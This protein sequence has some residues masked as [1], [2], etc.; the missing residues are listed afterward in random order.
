SAE[1]TNRNDAPVP[2]ADVGF[3]D[4]IGCRGDTAADEKIEGLCHSQEL[5]RAFRLGNRS[6]QDYLMGM[7]ISRLDDRAVIAISGPEAKSFLQ[8]L[9]TNDVE[10]VSPHR[11][12]YAALLTPQGKI[13][14]DFL[15]AVEDE[16]FLIDCLASARD[17]LVKRL[18]MYK[19]RAKV[20][21]KLR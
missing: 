2:D 9:I 3:C 11:A 15:I 8:G 7:P 10:Q 16:T 1:G 13:L 6:R 14:F 21:I 20:D 5:C 19:L 12:I 17:A 4:A 18:T